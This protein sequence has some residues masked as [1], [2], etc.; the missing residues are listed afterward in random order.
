[1]ALAEVLRRLQKFEEVETLNQL[2]LMGKELRETIL[3]LPDVQSVP[4]DVF[5]KMQR[6]AAGCGDELTATRMA[7]RLEQLTASGA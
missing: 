3:Q 2:S 5:Q 1:L 7:E 6:Y 4:V